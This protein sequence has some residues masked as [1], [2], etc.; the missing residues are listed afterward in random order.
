MRLKLITLLI[1]SLLFISACGKT[2]SSETA[3]TGADGSASD[4]GIKRFKQGQTSMD[5]K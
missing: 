5:L 4:L 1:I 3:G 2:E